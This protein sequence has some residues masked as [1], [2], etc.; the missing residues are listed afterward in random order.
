MVAVESV[1]KA[2]IRIATYYLGKLRQLNYAFISGGENILFALENFD[3][4]YNQM[5]HIIEW[6]ADNAVHDD[7]IATLFLAFVDAGKHI[8]SIRLSPE[9]YLKLHNHAL[10]LA[11]QQEDEEACL[12]HLSAIAY[13]YHLMGDNLQMQN[14][15]L[16]SCDLAKQTNNT[17]KLADCL[18]FLSLL[19][20]DFGQFDKAID[21]IDQALNL[22][23][24]MQDA[25][26]VTKSLIGLGKILMYK[27]DWEKANSY[28]QH[29]YQIARERN[30]QE[31]IMLAVQEIGEIKYLVGQYDE[32]IY[33]RNKALEIA[34]TLRQQAAVIQ[35]T[36]DLG[37]VYDNKR[38]F[39]TAKNYYLKALEITEA[40]G[41][42]R[43][44]SCILANIG[45]S[46]YMQSNYDTACQ[47]SEEAVQMLREEGTII[48][49][50]IVLAQMGS[51]YL[52][53]GFIEKTRQVLYEAVEAAI[54]FKNMQLC[55]WVIV[56]AV[57]LW[58]NLATNPCY[59]ADQYEL[60]SEAAQWSG[61]IYSIDNVEPLNRYEIEWLHPQ[62]E[63]IL[64]KEQVNA[65]L[66]QGEQLAVDD[67]L[68]HLLVK[69]KNFAV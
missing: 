21:A 58:V 64:G 15:L 34:T 55:G 61:L 5:E 52:A 1:N 13:A 62:I 43:H 22:Y 48:I 37:A 65:L 2:K 44:K 69:L 53:L 33:Y 9:E 40:T 42:Q 36:M 67:V 11:Q 19:Y 28:L 54:R 41:I 10:I 63:T 4:E 51:I 45:Y 59:Q 3:A 49:L 60:A 31:H 20:K 12:T 46:T 66:K 14:Y 16:Q 25:Y 57:Q 23:R 18:V 24:K 35:N 6:L 27:G 50:S 29:A 38:D 32:S 56:T 68:T 26:N 7:D 30:H 47:Y 39:K 17:E 8:I